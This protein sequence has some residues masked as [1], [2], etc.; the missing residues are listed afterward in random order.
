MSFSERLEKE[1]AEAWRL[2]YIARG[3]CD[4]QLLRST[5][6]RVA[7]IFE[8]VLVA[9]PAGSPEDKADTFV[10]AMIAAGHAS[11]LSPSAQAAVEQVVDAALASGK[12]IL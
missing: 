12:S 6:H 8:G 9:S 1:R 3:G 10:A 11:K 7:A 5:R 2:I 4:L